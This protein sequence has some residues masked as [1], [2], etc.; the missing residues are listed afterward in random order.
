MSGLSV[1]FS[2]R[3]QLLKHSKW[4]SIPNPTPKAA[5]VSLD[6]SPP[7]GHGTEEDEPLT[8]NS[9]PRTRWKGTTLESST[10]P[11]ERSVEDE[12]LKPF[13]KGRDSSSGPYSNPGSLRNIRNRHTDSQHGL[14]SNFEL[15]T[16]IP[17]GRPPIPPQ[18]PDGSI[19]TK[20]D[21]I[22]K[23]HLIRRTHTSP[24]PSDRKFPEHT[25][26]VKSP[27]SNDTEQADRKIQAQAQLRPGKLPN[28]VLSDPV[29]RDSVPPRRSKN[30]L[31]RSH[32]SGVVAFELYKAKSDTR[33][34][35]SL[36]KPMIENM[37][38][39]VSSWCR[40]RSQPVPQPHG[41]LRLV[42]RKQAVPSQ[43]TSWK[44]CLWIVLSYSLRF[45]RL[46]NQNEGHDPLPK[47]LQELIT[48]WSYFLK[49]FGECYI[50]GLQGTIQQIQNSD[51]WDKFA[52]SEQWKEVGRESSQEL[53]Q[54]IAH[55]LP[56][57]I[58]KDIAKVDTAILSTFVLLN[59]HEEL[60]SSLDQVYQKQAVGFLNFV[61]HLLPNSNILR[62]ISRHQKTLSSRCLVPADMVYMIQ[63][64]TEV[65]AK[66]VSTAIS[67]DQAKQ[68]TLIKM[69]DPFAPNESSDT[70]AFTMKKISKMV[71]KQNLDG[72]DRLWVDTKKLFA[73][74]DQNGGIPEDIYSRF[75]LAYVQCQRPDRSI[76]VFNHMVQN[77]TIPLTGHWGTLLQGFGV[78]KNLQEVHHIWQKVLGQGIKPDS[79]LWTTRIHSLM[80]CHQWRDGF[81]AF[82]EMARM[83]VDA[84]N[85][86]KKDKKIDNI[87]QL[88]DIGDVPKPTTR[89]LNATV[90]GLSRH[91]EYDQ[92]ARCLNLAK[93][94][95]IKPDTYTFNP[96]FKGALL[97]GNTDLA[98]RLLQQMQNM[99]AAPDIA[100]FTVMLDIAFRDPTTAAAFQ[101]FTLNPQTS[102]PKLSS[103]PNTIP[104]PPNPSLPEQASSH[105]STK[106]ITSLMAEASLT[107]TIRKAITTVFTLMD[108]ASLQPTEHTF[109]TLISG[110]LTSYPPSVSAAY[111][112]FHHLCARNLRFTSQIYD[113][114]IHFHFR[115]NPPDLD[116][117]KALWVHARSRQWSQNGL[118]LD[119]LF[120]Q[121]LIEGWSLNGEVRLAVEAWEA[122]GKKRRPVSW[123]ALH[124]LAEA[125]AWR[126]DWATVR[127]VVDAQRGKEG[128]VTGAKG[129]G[130]AK[131][132]YEFWALVGR[133]GFASGPKTEEEGEDKG[134]DAGLAA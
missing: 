93:S 131:R 73:S 50:L 41:L 54:K 114:L 105:N 90:F 127:Q 7:T 46:E 121:R 18:T 91:G 48:L 16:G 24:K 133:W 64:I 31:Y 70:A 2:C 132:R 57:S 126:R 29:P 22:R 101:Q 129:F 109:A 39:T 28:S 51:D 71:G 30:S 23:R 5:F 21:V 77:G 88:G 86:S 78:A 27:D 8:I 35:D 122:A 94:L 55:F 52:R 130:S 124:A 75:I 118:V 128:S 116:A 103:G 36:Q 3:R 42:G 99:G 62:R 92:L 10:P 82:L 125:L 72:L 102:P 96:L 15:L 66:T 111:T 38:E 83:W 53:S 17:S 60:V 56:Q 1:C 40:K 32:S 33:S 87:A 107:P 123:E 134:G 120:Y 58:H 12:S 37:Y 98:Q 106:T 95:G 25:A 63:R 76:E 13:S 84:A 11:N 117:V 112:V 44:K 45:S 61:E 26:A 65:G 9:E 67:H 119:G 110:L 108:R 14:T 113:S 59:K 81:N 89:C 85:E 4:P 20:E 43:L 80:N 100:T 79:W 6:A 115:Q 74:P 69:T 97:D 68:S 47:L 49:S 104:S 19:E 34:E